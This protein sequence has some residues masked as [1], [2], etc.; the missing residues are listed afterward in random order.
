M[1]VHV[2]PGVLFVTETLLITSRQQRGAAGAAKRMRHIAIAET[3]ALARQS[4]QMRRG[5]VLAALKA[6]IRIALIV[7]DDDEEVGVV[8]GFGRFSSRSFSS[9]PFRLSKK[10]KNA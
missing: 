1:V 9:C 3:K 5:D 8:G 2:I 6:D 4:V 10:Q 7:R